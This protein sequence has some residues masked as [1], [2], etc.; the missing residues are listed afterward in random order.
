MSD[1]HGHLPTLN[2][3][4]VDVVTISGDIVPLDIQGK[5]ARSI[6]WYLLQ[7]V[8]WAEKLPCKKVF[9]IAG[10]HDFFFEAQISRK[11]IGTLGPVGEILLCENTSDKVVYLED[12][13]YNFEGKKF[14]GTP[15]IPDLNRW[16]FYGNSAKLKEM[17]GMIPENVDV[18]LTHTAPRIGNAGKVLQTSAFN[19][20]SNFG[21]VELTE[22]I[23]KKK[24]KYVFCGHIH[25]GDHNE[26]VAECGTRIY[27]VSIKDEDYLPSYT[28]KLI[29]I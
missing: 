5:L 15:W 18:L 26:T 7:F 8:P 25:S 9:V 17:F 19:Y 22:A 4:E 3:P 12:R 20:G 27:N 16:A 2:I 6:S 1:L 21:C 24:P 23:E 10:N 11:N 13:E 14:W 28:G 29:E